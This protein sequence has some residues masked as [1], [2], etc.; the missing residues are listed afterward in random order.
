MSAPPSA[1]GSN[2]AYN[3]FKGS[4]FNGDVDASQNIICR[5]GNLY[6]ASNSSIYSP[7]NQINFDDTYQYLNC[8]QNIHIFGNT[9]C[10][11]NFTLEAG[12]LSMPNNSSIQTSGNSITFDDSYN[13]INIPNNFHIYQQFQLDYG[14]TTYNVGDTISNIGNMDYNPTYTQHTFTN[15][16]ATD[17]LQIRDALANDINLTPKLRDLYSGV[18]VANNISNTFNLQQNFSSIRLDGSLI[19]SNNS[20]TLSN[21]N[22]SKIQFLSNVVSDVNTSLANRVDLTSVQTISASKNFGGTQNFTNIKLDG[23]LAVQTGTITLTN[24][25]ISRLSGVTSNIQSQLTT[26]ANKL[27][28]V[29]Y[30]STLNN[31]NVS[32]NLVSS[33]FQCTSICRIDGSFFVTGSNQY[34]NTQLNNVMS[35]CN[36][37]TQNVETNLNSVKTKLTNQ[38]YNSNTNTTSWS[39]SLSFPAGSISTSAIS[40]GVVSLG[41]N[42]TYTGLNTYNSGVQMS[43]QFACV[44]NTNGVQIACYGGRT[45]D[46]GTAG[47]IVNEWVFNNGSQKGF[48]I[49]GGGSSTYGEFGMY[50]IQTTPAFA[51]RQPIMYGKHTGNISGDTLNIA[52][53]TLSC[54]SITFNG[55]LNSISPTTLSYVDFSSSGQSQINSANSNIS[56]LQGQMTTANSNISSLQ[57]TLT[58]AS[59]VSADDT[60]YFFGTLFGQ[61]LT[62]Q[63]TINGISTTIFTYLSGLTQNIQATFNSFNSSISSLNSSV[64]SINNSLP[65]VGSVIYTFGSTESSNFL[66][67]NGQALS[68]T[69]YSV[70]FGIIGTTYGAPDANTFNLPN[71]NGLYVRCTGSQTV[72]SK[73]YTAQSLGVK[74]QD[75]VESHTH[76]GGAGSYLGTTN[77]TTATN[78][79]S[80]ISVQKPNSFSFPTSGAM[81]SGLSGTETRPVSIAMTALIRVL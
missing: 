61:S 54:K 26:S 36:S 40:G 71:V 38:S 47:D 33:V 51:T 79:Y 19:V 60:T 13:F 5:N 21:S 32:G 78:G 10:G 7:T 12:N 48:T 45:W 63:N 55:T 68:R 18:Y 35:N 42:N 3:R 50:Y 58:R 69:T 53:N 52:S 4:Y 46:N 43:N 62:F 41:S 49:Q 37:L 73:T 20:L 65:P 22:L 8:L 72:G 9:I 77:Q 24:L 59:Y 81:N 76:S 17:M 11:N 30:N 6:L 2:T 16:L 34:S 64:S 25:E 57:Q 70:L 74:Q 67:C 31:T 28:N 15:I 75:Q 39:G 1:F 29:S 66:F 44:D 80:A 27:T 23:T 56:T 14:G